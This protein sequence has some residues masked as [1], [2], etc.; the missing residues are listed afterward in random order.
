M[1]SDPKLSDLLC[2]S[3]NVWLDL[4]FQNDSKT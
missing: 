4:N 2:I 1:E 3:L